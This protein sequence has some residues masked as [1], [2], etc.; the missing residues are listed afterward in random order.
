MLNIEILSKLSFLNTIYTGKQS[1][2]DSIYTLL[3]CYKY[4]R[5]RTGIV[6]FGGNT[7]YALVEQKK[8]EV[9]P[10]AS[11]TAGG[12]HGGGTAVPS[13]SSEPN[14]SPEWVFI[15]FVFS[16]KLSS[17][18]VNCGFPLYFLIWLFNSVLH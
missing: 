10:S 6:K 3:F 12:T 9:R 4:S 16:H 2:N 13:V 17:Q 5:E 8:G 1:S 7:D 18:L 11:P 14:T 15:L